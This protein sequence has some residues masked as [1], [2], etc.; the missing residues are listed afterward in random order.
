MATSRAPW[1]GQPEKPTADIFS[2]ALRR[3]LTLATA[4]TEES[5]DAPAALLR[6][7]EGL[8]P[9]PGE[10]NSD[11]GSIAGS[12]RASFDI[13]Y[14]LKRSGGGRKNKGSGKQHVSAVNRTQSCGSIRTHSHGTH[15]APQ[16]NVR[17]HLL[18]TE[19]HKRLSAQVLL[20]NFP[21]ALHRFAETAVLLRTR[22][23]DELNYLQLFVALCSLLC[24]CQVCIYS[25]VSLRENAL[26]IWL[27]VLL[28]AVQ[29]VRPRLPAWRPTAE[30]V[31]A[32]PIEL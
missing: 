11:A 30:S 9:S 26:S 17:D 25:A 2:L 16:L 28:V 5:A 21:P 29:R 19:F 24:A 4:R 20:A 12:N 3:R 7:G 1:D 23:F 13:T 10:S 18:R 14:S 8:L 27:K 31:S 22:S 32:C 15:P 6:E